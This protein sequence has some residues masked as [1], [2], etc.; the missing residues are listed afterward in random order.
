MDAINTAS[1]TKY[2]VTND[3]APVSA[4]PTDTITIGTQTWMKYNSDV[5]TMITGATAQ[6]NNSVLEKYCYNNET[7]NCTIYGG[8][9]Q[10][11][12]AMQYVTT[13]GAQGICPAGSHIPSDSE[14]TTLTTYLGATTAGTQLKLGGTSGLSMPLTGSRYPN[15]SFQDLSLSAE[16]WSSS[17][18]ST[19]A[20]DRNLNSSRATVSRPANDKVYGFSVRCMRN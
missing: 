16:L 13:Q 2:R 9:Y 12:E 18:S 10:W 3:S 20:W 6:T 8:L 14:W 15:G 1:T 17:E 7:A 4:M 19:S 11:D 5:G